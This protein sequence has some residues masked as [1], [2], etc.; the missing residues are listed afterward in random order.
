MTKEDIEEEYNFEDFNLRMLATAYKDHKS[1]PDGENLPYFS[2]E[3]GIK[4]REY[5]PDGSKF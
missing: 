4:T 1:I 2:F 3:Y 5:T